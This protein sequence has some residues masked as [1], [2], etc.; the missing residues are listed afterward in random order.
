MLALVD[1]A[2]ATSP[3][4]FSNGP[5]HYRLEIS[6]EQ[7]AGEDQDG[8]AA[9]EQRHL[10]ISRAFACGTRTF[11]QSASACITRSQV[12]LTA[13]INLYRIDEAG[14]TPVV[15][16]RTFDAELW[17][18]GYTLKYA[19]IL[20]GSYGTGSTTTQLSLISSDAKTFKLERFRIVDSGFWVEADK[21]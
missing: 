20:S 7:R 17:V 19:Q 4:D 18:D 21:K 10:L 12:L 8:T 2:N 15:Q 11:M 14:M 13:T 6:F 1:E 3:F 9:V 16:N 5:D